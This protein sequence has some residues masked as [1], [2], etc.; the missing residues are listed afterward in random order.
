MS[1]I[2]LFDVTNLSIGIKLEGNIFHKMIPRSKPIPYNTKEIFHTVNDNQTSASIEIFEGEIKNNCNLN[3]FLLGKF[4]IYGLPKR[5]KE[6]LKLKYQYTLKKIQ[7][8]KLQQ[9][10]M[11][12]K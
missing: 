3:N 12:I 11:I 5:K 8:W 10:K 9:L 4:M 2:I 6:R 7:Y 1:D